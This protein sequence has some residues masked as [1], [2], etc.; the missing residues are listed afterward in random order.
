MNQSLL[1]SSKFDHSKRLVANGIGEIVLGKDKEACRE[2]D[3]NVPIECFEGFNG[4]W[5]EVTVGG[6]DTQLVDVGGVKENSVKESGNECVATL[7]NVGVM[8][9]EMDNNCGCLNVTKRVNRVK[10][11]DLRHYG[12]VNLLCCSSEETVIGDKV[13]GFDDKD[14]GLVISNELIQED[15]GSKELESNNNYVRLRSNPLLISP[16]MFKESSIMFVENIPFKD[17]RYFLDDEKLKCL[18]WSERT[19]WQEGLNETIEWYTN[20]LDWWVDVSG[21]LLRQLRLLMMLGEVGKVID[22]PKNVVGL[23]G[24]LCEKQGIQYK[25]E[26]KTVGGAGVSP[27]PTFCVKGLEEVAKLNEVSFDYLEFDI[28]KWPTRKKIKEKERRVSEKRA[29]ELVLLVG[30]VDKWVCRRLNVGWVEDIKEGKL[31]SKDGIMKHSPQLPFKRY[32]EIGRVG[33]VNYGPDYGKLVV[34]VDV[35]DQ[36]RALVDS[37]DMVRSQLNFKRLT[38]TDIKIDIKRVPNKKTLIAALEAADVKNKWENSSWGRKLIVQKKRASLN[39]FDRFKIMLA[40]I[41]KAGVVRQELA[42]LKKESTA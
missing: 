9:K 22:V 16:E 11:M 37:P 17:Q 4:Q 24:K 33:L 28:G 3:K 21:A 36:N 12:K 8:R 18:G 26:K 40:K 14:N 6:Y 15:G 29:S 1:F 34:I 25:Y 5:A 7:C 42:K 41:K 35:I 2:C 38:L 31:V 10:K 30:L 27:F 32:V 39:D 20:N 13:I 19:T 23:L